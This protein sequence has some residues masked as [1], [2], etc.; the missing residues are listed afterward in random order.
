MN[1]GIFIWYIC[2]KNCRNCTLFK[3]NTSGIFTHWQNLCEITDVNRLF[4]ADGGILFAG[5]ALTF[6]T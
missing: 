6:A 1:N 4:S 3:R 5:F 2:M